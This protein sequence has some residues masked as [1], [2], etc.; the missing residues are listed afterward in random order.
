MNFLIGLAIIFAIFDRQYHFLAVCIIWLIFINICPKSI[1]ETIRA[2]IQQIII[3]I[4]IPLVFILQYYRAI[5]QTF[6]EMGF[7]WELILTKILPLYILYRTFY[8]ML[9]YILPHFQPRTLQFMAILMAFIG[10][11]NSFV[12]TIYLGFT[13][14]LLYSFGDPLLFTLFI[15]LL[16]LCLQLLDWAIMSTFAVTTLTK[17]ER[18]EIYK[19]IYTDGDRKLSSVIS[20]VKDQIAKWRATRDKTVTKISKKIE[21]DRWWK[22]YV[23]GEGFVQG[24]IHRRL[25]NPEWHKKVFKDYYPVVRGMPAAITGRGFAPD[26]LNYLTGAYP[27]AGATR[28]LVRGNIAKIAKMTPPSMKGNFF[29]KIGMWLGDRFGR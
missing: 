6:F 20:H 27:D 24:R 26:I 25:L 19:R 4:G 1:T 9:S 28:N 3:G 8:S 22:K 10:L 2:I 18:E 15:G 17:D 16:A 5:L 11:N 29:Q 21:K 14:M 13:T 7:T 23:G 12:R